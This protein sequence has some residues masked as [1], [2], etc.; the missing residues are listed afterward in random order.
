LRYLFSVC[1]S[2]K[3]GDFDPSVPSPSEMNLAFERWK[4][5]SNALERFPFLNQE[6]LAAYIRDDVA[7]HDKLVPAGG[8]KWSSV[9]TRLGISDREGATKTNQEID[10][11][12]NKA[13]DIFHRDSSKIV[14]KKLFQ[15]WRTLWTPF[16]Y[17]MK[18]YEFE[19]GHLESLKKGAS[20][21]YVD[22]VQLATATKSVQNMAD[23]YKRKT[24]ELR[25]VLNIIRSRQDNLS[26]TIS[27]LCD[28]LDVAISAADQDEWMNDKAEEA[29]EEEIP[30][31]KA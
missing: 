3:R 31:D 5:R 7:L 23:E 28:E 30:T 10:V 9:R 21:S 1:R 18:K 27:L 2:A 14:A 6:M 17:A 20:Q 26:G 19:K 4:K 11:L 12:V 15:K 29:K 22:S 13:R 8:V 16:D 24:D 25:K